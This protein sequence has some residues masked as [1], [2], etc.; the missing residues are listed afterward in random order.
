MTCTHKSESQRAD[1]LKHTMLD[2]GWWLRDVK[3]TT[4][5]CGKT[6]IYLGPIESRDHFDGLS[7]GPLSFVIGIECLRR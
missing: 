6:E 3:A 4:V 1:G 5:E 7:T 2:L